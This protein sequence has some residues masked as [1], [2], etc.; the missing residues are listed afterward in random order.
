MNGD[1]QV[2]AL[3]AGDLGAATQRD[4]VVAGP[5]QFGAEA[6]HAV[7]LALQL[8]R[9][10][11]H[12]V[13]LT[14]ATGPGGPRV[15][16]AMPGIDD[17]DNVAFAS[18][19]RRQ[20]DR[21]L[22][23]S[24]RH[25]RGCGNAWGRRRHGRRRSIGRVIEEIDH[26]SVAVLRVRREHEALR[27]HGLF[28]VDDHPQVGWCTLRRTHGGDRC[29]GG[30]DVQRRAQCCAID[31]DHQAIR[32]RQ[33]EDAVLNRARQVEHQA[34]VVRR[35]PQAN[36]VHLCRS[37]GVDGQCRK[38]HSYDSNQRAKAHT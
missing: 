38:Q 27:G 35:P 33:G 32:G 1:E 16:A 6:F 37:H 31:V 9:D 21:R 20:L 30:G 29:I 4:E 28:Q 19:S 17:Y 24:H 7:D 36:A 10:R 18:R 26:Q 22:S 23:R 3:L 5:G 14:L 13:F 25:R 8:T 2:C 12:H 11:Q 34:R 15:F